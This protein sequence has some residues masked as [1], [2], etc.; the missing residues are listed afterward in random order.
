M[1]AMAGNVFLLALITIPDHVLLSIAISLH[2]KKCEN[3]SKHKWTGNDEATS[4][5][6]KQK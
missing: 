5:I 3:F 1:I 4:A 6:I 2:Y